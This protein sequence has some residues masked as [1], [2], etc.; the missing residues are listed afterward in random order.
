MPNAEPPAGGV[1]TF[2][3]K[4][5][6]TEIDFGKLPALARLSVTG[7]VKPPLDVTVTVKTVD[8]PGEI[9]CLAG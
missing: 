7:E 1:T 9:V 3:G 8:M 6:D 5:E 2:E 4:K